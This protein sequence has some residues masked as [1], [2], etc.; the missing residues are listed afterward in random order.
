[1]NEQQHPCKRFLNL[2]QPL[3]TRPVVIAIA[4]SL[5]LHAVLLFG[6]NLITL[7]PVETALPP[8]TAKLEPLPKTTVKPAPKP[9]AHAKQKPVLSPALPAPASQPEPP[10]EVVAPPVEE[11]QPAATEIAH[12]A[13]KP[14]HPLPRHA[15]LTFT[16][17]KGTNIRVGEARHRLEIRDDNSYTLQVGMNTTGIASLFKTFELNQQSSGHVGAQGLQPDEFTENKLTSK[18]RQTLSA[19]FN[20][21]NKQLEFSGGNSTALPEQA[22]DILSFLYQFSQMQLDQTTLPM[23]VSNGRKLESYQLEVG[24]EEDIQTPL[25]K[26]RALPL[27]KLHAPGE[28]G[29]E[30]WLG[31]EYRL[32]PVKIIQIDRNGEIAGELVISDIRVSDE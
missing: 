3:L 8:L 9:R 24:S 17:Y 12:E 13:A 27:R 11:V 26:L 22:Q 4:L 21:D 15:Q 14:V 31:M 18:G 30:I 6:P 2:P 29:L 10:P 28:E 20:R 19:K 23:H 1:M 7:A 25:G 32:L 16:A 5:L